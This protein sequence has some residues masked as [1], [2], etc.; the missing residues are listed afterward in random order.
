MPKNDTYTCE[1]CGEPAQRLAQSYSTGLFECP[2]CALEDVSPFMSADI[3]RGLERRA[4]EHRTWRGRALR[5]LRNF[6]HTQ[7]EVTA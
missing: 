6:G 4:R 1:T 2:P 3:R 7:E 5:A